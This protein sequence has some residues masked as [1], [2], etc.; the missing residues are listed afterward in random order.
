MKV[1]F[2]RRLEQ[3]LSPFTIVH[4]ICSKFFFLRFSFLSGELNIRHMSPHYLIVKWLPRVLSSHNIKGDSREC[5]QISRE[6]LIFKA[7]LFR[8]KTPYHTQPYTTS[9]SCYLP[10]QFLARE[11]TATW[12]QGS[13]NFVF[14]HL[15]VT[16]HLVKVTCPIQKVT[17]PIKKVCCPKICIY[18]SC[19]FNVSGR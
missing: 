14:N 9:R 7:S 15:S 19:N 16:R 12:C 11:A 17:C 18:N 4:P 2:P 1:I 3:S 13:P 8:G 5:Q 10:L 6:A